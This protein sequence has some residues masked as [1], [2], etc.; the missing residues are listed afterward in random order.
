V[1]GDI[2][3]M[4]QFGG[5]APVPFIKNSGAKLSIGIQTH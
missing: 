1:Q 5:A 2:S 4:S 3:Y